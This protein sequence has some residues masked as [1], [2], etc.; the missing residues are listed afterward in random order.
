MHF[1]FYLS[2]LLECLDLFK[3]IIFYLSAVDG[4]WGRLSGAAVLGRQ[5]GSP[6]VKWLP[7]AHTHLLAARPHSHC[8][9]CEHCLHTKEDRHFVTL[10]LASSP[11]HKFKKGTGHHNNINSS[12]QLFFFSIF[13]YNSPM[14][15]IK[16]SLPVLL[17]RDDLLFSGGERAGSCMPR[18]A[19]GR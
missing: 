6:W 10:T 16:E 11:P 1:L 17:C 4:T 14:K 8:W 12:R 5:S 19:E 2:S 9:N 18:V 15:M 7:A 13:L 3:L